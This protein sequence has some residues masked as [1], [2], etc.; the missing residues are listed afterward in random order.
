MKVTALVLQSWFD[1]AIQYTGS[2]MNAYAIAYANGGRSVTDDIIPGELIT[3]P[4]TVPIFKK[5]VQYLENKEI[6]PATGITSA[7]FEAINPVLGIG[8]MT[9]GS[10]FIIG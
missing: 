8:Q 5:E 3:I 2:V 9:I 10:T 1:I 7:D 4:D 6:V